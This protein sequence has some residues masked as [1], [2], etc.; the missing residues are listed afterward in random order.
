MENLSD[1]VTI[2]TVSSLM[3]FQ[4]QVSCFARYSIQNVK[5]PIKRKFIEKTK[6]YTHFFLHL[7]CT[8]FLEN[9]KQTNIKMCCYACVFY[10]LFLFMSSCMGFDLLL[11][12]T[13]L[14][15]CCFVF[16][17]GGS[18]LSTVQLF[19]IIKICC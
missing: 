1:F 6:M 10:W 11:H 3:N 5:W 2:A 8:L 14:G 17:V 7:L 16:M 12:H 4:E 18:V 19:L 15:V 13:L 9:N